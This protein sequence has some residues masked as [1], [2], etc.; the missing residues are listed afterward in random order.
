MFRRFMVELGVLPVVSR[1]YTCG[2]CPVVQGLSYQSIGA[3]S[4]QG[5]LHLD[6]K[7]LAPLPLSSK[8]AVDTPLTEH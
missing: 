8:P 6:P 5:L 7:P 3:T 1:L 4:L 2:V